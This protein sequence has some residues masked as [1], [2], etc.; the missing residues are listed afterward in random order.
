MRTSLTGDA[1]LLPSVRVTVAGIVLLVALI[2]AGCAILDALGPSGTRGV[3]FTYLGDS[4]L[5]VGQPQPVDVTVAVDGVQL[6]PQRLRV[7]ILPDSTKVTLNATGDTL[8][9]CRA[10]Q[11]SLLVRLL[12]SSA[13]GLAD[14]TFVLR[15]FGG[16]PPGS[17]CP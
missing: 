4:T 2:P 13:S 7:A 15:V 12:H 17:R 6:A 11:A 1:P 14:T 5:S 3:T 16:A 9:P 10:G 8:I